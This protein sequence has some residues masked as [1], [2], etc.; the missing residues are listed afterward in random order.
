M[1][2]QGNDAY[3]GELRFERAQSP[4]TFV[5]ENFNVTLKY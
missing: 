5:W 3:K 2:L 4:H 1:E